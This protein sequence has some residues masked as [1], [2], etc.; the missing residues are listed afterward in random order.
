MYVLGERENST[1][2]KKNTSFNLFGDVT[3]NSKHFTTK[4]DFIISGNNLILGYN[5]VIL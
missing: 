1:S 2:T 5:N 3:V 4:K